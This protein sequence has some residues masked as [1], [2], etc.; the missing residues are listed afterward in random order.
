MLRGKSVMSLE[1][2]SNLWPLRLSY[3][4]KR[5]HRLMSDYV[6]YSVSEYCTQYWNGFQILNGHNRICWYW[7]TRLEGLNIITKWDLLNENTPLKDVLVNS[8]Y[9]ICLILPTCPTHPP[10]E[11]S[12]YGHKRVYS[13]T[14]FPLWLTVRN[15]WRA[16]N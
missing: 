3:V 1:Y 9:F 12:S 2:K 16:A 6:Q 15:L 14:P 7:W 4:Y 10:C 8:S 11:H 13:Y 5:F